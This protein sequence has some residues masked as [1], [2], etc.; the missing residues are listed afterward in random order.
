MLNNY[1]RNVYKSKV[2]S[3]ETLNKNLKNWRIS[4]NHLSR[5]FHFDNFDG[6]MQFV[7]IA[8]QYLKNHQIEG[9]M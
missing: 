4:N 2:V 6:A 9:K 3:K 5:T 8:G 7:T 1:L